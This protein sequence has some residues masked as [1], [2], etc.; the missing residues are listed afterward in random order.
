MPHFFCTLAVGLR[1][2][3]R[4]TI[5]KRWY[6]DDTL[7]TMAWLSSTVV[8]VVYSIAAS[9]EHILNAV[10]NVESSIPD[11]KPYLMRTYLGLIFYQI[12]LCL[13]KL[14]VL[15]F[16]LRMFSERRRERR[17]AWMTVLW[18]TVYGTPLLFLSIFQCHPAP[19]L[20]F[21]A[22]MKCFEFTTLLIA[23]ASLHS[24]TD[25]WL[26]L[27]IVPCVSKLELPSKQKLALTIILGMSV[28][29][30]AASM[31]RLHLSI[32]QEYKP[33]SV[34]VAHTQGF[35]V[36]TILECDIAIICATAPTLR[37]LFLKYC[38]VF[39]VHGFVNRR[40]RRGLN[41]S[42]YSLPSWCVG[43]SWKVE[44]PGH[45]AWGQPSPVASA[46]PDP[47]ESGPKNQMADGLGISMPGHPAPALV[48]GH[49]NIATPSPGSDTVGLSFPGNTAGDGQEETRIKSA[50]SQNEQVKRNAID[51]TM[52]RIPVRHESLCKRQSTHQSPAKPRGAG[53]PA[54]GRFDGTAGGLEVPHLTA[55]RGEPSQESFVLSVD[56]PASL[57]KPGRRSLRGGACQGLHN[58]CSSIRIGGKEGYRENA[59]DGERKGSTE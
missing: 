25:V 8:L 38:P 56:D 14:S 9:N 58:D 13:T 6:I 36:L 26:V 22:P 15:A 20:F 18:V 44:A 42:R 39:G 40:R 51:P 37:L 17:M 46:F 53:E 23:S 48:A 11:L 21:G 54:C 33:T 49:Y 7:I 19:G 27:M 12:C 52:Q 4:Y 50:V 24:I 47:S 32:H 5:T 16:Y 29:I 28:F 34:Q 30:I 2:V 1:A 55:G 43:Y 35:F 57:G 41:N 10:V 31:T 45:Q 3:C 59:A